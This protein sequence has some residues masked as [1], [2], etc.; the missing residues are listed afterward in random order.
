M[1]LVPGFIAAFAA[2]GV[3]TAAPAMARTWP[4]IELMG[5]KWGKEGPTEALRSR[6]PVGSPE[7]ALLDALR[8]S[9]FKVAGKPNRAGERWAR[10]YWG[11]GMACTDIYSVYWRTDPQGA[12][13][14]IHG[15]VQGAC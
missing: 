1:R 7:T 13:A 4:L 6:F 5:R 3:L 12:L 10:N 14:D 15:E 9:K 11:G 8:D 2:V